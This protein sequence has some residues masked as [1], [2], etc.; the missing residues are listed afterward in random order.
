MAKQNIVREPIV[1]H[2]VNG[3]TSF[4]ETFGEIYANLWNEIK[5]GTEAVEKLYD[6]EGTIGLRNLA[7]E[8]TKRFERKHKGTNWAETD[9]LDAVDEFTRDRVSAMAEDSEFGNQRWSCCYDRV[10]SGDRFCP[11]CGEPI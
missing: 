8:W 10:T 2:M 4:I 9:F 7:L 6:R 11:T 1:D 5:K 3:P